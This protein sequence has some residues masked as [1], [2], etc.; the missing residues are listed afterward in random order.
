MVTKTLTELADQADSPSEFIRRYLSMLAGWLEQSDFQDGCPITTT[1]LETTPASGIISQ[2]GQTVFANWRQIIE[3]LLMKH[4]WPPDEA[5]TLSTFVIV[6]MEGALVLARVEKSAQPIH[7]TSS[8][9]CR[10]L[11]KTPA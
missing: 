3:N 7:D 8:M 9:L 10:L 5:K 11:E 4:G 6:G 1:L 2:A